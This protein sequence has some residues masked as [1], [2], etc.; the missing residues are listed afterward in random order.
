MKFC[1][2]CGS[3]MLPARKGDG[4]VLRCRSCGYEISAEAGGSGYKRTISVERKPTD[5]IIVIE[6]G[7]NVA[8]LPRMK[9][10]CPKCGHDEAFYWEMQTR[11]ADEP[12]TRFFRCTKCG[13]VWREY[14]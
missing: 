4:R 2:K 10:Q 5:K 7:V 6:G 14:E 3:I 1:P 9:T 8:T 11:S 12:S 13:H